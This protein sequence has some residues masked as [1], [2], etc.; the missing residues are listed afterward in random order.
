MYIW[1]NIL[2]HKASV[3]VVC[4][5]RVHTK[6][7]STSNSLDGMSPGRTGVVQLILGGRTGGSC[8]TGLQAVL[9]GNHYVHDAFPP[10]SPN[11]IIK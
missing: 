2:K 11:Q 8:P 1:H 7:D 9:T 5:V 6:L 4:V 10:F 3:P